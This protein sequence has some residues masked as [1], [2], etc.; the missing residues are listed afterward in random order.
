MSGFTAEVREELAALPVASEREARSELAGILLVLGPGAGPEA[1]GGAAV[2]G[3]AGEGG[4]PGDLPLAALCGPD[5]LVVEHAA[6]P[7]ARRTVALVLRAFGVRPALVVRRGGARGVVN[8]VL[9]P[10]EPIRRR[11]A[12]PRGRPA[13]VGEG[14]DPETVALLRGVLLA[15]GAVSAP[16]RPPHLELGPLSAPA[17]A[18]VVAGLDQTVATRA[19]HD[20]TRRRVI[21][22]AGGAIADLLALTGAT[23]AFLAVDERRL[24]RQLRADATRLA[25][26]DAANLERTARRAGAEVA[27]IRAAVERAGWEAFDAEL[28]EVALARLAN[29]EASLR[30]LSVLLAVPRATLHRRLRRVEVLSRHALGSDAVADPA[31]GG[32]QDPA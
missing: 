23:R 29:P 27:A 8:R 9:V 20:P 1:A 32:P 26:A 10:L 13:P 15:G 7:V 2:L 21:V 4:R 17:A 31:P 6:A 24:R 30:E 19:H 28:R 22:K 25:N 12:A 18:L 11:D 16:G 5:G 3:A 14:A